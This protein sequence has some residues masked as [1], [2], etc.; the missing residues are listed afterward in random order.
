M[1]AARGSQAGRNHR[2]FVRERFVEPA[3]YEGGD[4]FERFTFYIA[5][6]ELLALDLRNLLS[7]ERAKGS[8]IRRFK[9]NSVI[10]FARSWESSSVASVGG[11]GMRVL[12]SFRAE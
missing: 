7:G 2:E 12:G 1:L 8:E 4:K 3:F 11:P 5:V 10:T 9:M 6:R